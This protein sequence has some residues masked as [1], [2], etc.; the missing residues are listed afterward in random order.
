MIAEGTETLINFKNKSFIKIISNNNNELDLIKLSA[1]NNIRNQTILK[2]KFRVLVRIALSIK[3]KL[4]N[5]LQNF[6]QEKDLT[7]NP[8]GDHH[9]F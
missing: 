3:G 5:I 9:A 1:K 2:T 7:F 8:S 4:N 6:H